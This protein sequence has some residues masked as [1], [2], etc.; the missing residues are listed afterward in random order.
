MSLFVDSTEFRDMTDP[1]DTMTRSVITNESTV[2]SLAITLGSDV[3]SA[4]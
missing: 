1:D 3:F 2:G 4:R